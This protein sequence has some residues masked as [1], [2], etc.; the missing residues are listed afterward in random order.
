MSATQQIERYIELANG[1][2]NRTDAVT[3]LY[4]A[5]FVCGDTPTHEAHAK[6]AHAALQAI[7][8]YPH[9]DIDLALEPFRTTVARVE[10]ERAN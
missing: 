2:T 8:G 5:W 3:L 4:G 6:Q 7:P 1:T 10:R 9:H